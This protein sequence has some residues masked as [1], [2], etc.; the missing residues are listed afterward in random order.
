M[1]PEYSE[2][3]KTVLLADNCSV[4]EIAIAL[5]FVADKQTLDAKI[6]IKGCDGSLLSLVDWNCSECDAD[7]NTS[8]VTCVFNVESQQVLEMDTL[9]IV[10]IVVSDKDGFR[11]HSQITTFETR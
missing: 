5:P 3:E 8:L 2:S 4:V 11:K 10:E 9:P 7:S 1:E 6:E